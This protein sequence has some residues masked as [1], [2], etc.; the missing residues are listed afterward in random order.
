MNNKI[1]VAIVLL[2]FAVACRKTDHP[3][4]GTAAVHVYDSSMGLRVADTI[5]YDVIIRN[6]N[7]DDAWAVRCLKGLDHSLLVDS[8]FRMIYSGKIAAYNHETNEK[9]T[10]KQVEKI[11]SAKGFDRNNISMIQFTEVWYLNP[12]EVS[13]TKKVLSMVLGYDYYTPDGEL[14]HKALFRVEMGK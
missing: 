2:I 8:I 9:L 6:S 1:L 7:P 11:E 5:I 4:A 3:A 13:M 12:A 14:F 10:S